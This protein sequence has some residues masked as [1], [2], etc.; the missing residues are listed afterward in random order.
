MLKNSN[1]LEQMERLKAREGI[2][3]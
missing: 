1:K 3:G 2:W